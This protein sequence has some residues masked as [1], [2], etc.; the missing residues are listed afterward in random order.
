MYCL[1]FTVLSW[2]IVS[3]SFSFYFLRDTFDNMLV[4]ASIL[5]YL[6]IRAIPIIAD[7]AIKSVAN[8]NNLMQ[9]CLI[10]FQNLMGLS[11]TGCFV[12]HKGIWG[13]HLKLVMS[14]TWVAKIFHGQTAIWETEA[15][16][17][18]QLSFMRVFCVANILQSNNSCAMVIMLINRCR[19]LQI[20]FCNTRTGNQPMVFCPLRFPSNWKTAS[21]DKIFQF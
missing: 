12:C 4:P 1:Y 15:L 3:L 16:N 21:G 11:K 10:I 9:F 13:C 20:F 17:T 2:Y 7:L 8:A 5:S 19:I 6:P 18:S 14:Q